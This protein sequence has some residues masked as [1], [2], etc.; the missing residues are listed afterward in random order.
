[1]MPGYSFIPSEAS[2]TKPQKNIQFIMLKVIGKLWLKQYL[3]KEYN[4]V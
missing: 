1:M 2:I 3:L 4:L